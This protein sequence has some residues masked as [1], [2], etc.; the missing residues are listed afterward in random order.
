MKLVSGR[1]AHESIERFAVLA[2]VAMLSVLSP[3]H[4][5]DLLVSNALVAHSL[6]HVIVAPVDGDF[7]LVVG[8]DRP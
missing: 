3:A 6:E 7:R 2:V 8:D 5:A 4:A 1:R